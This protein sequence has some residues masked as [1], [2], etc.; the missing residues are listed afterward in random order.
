MRVAQRP[1]LTLDE[2]AY[3][4]NVEIPDAWGTVVGTIDVKLPEPPS[5]RLRT[6]PEVKK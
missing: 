6:E 4:L 2:V 1:R 3:V 5:A